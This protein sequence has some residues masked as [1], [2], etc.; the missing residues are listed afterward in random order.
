MGSPD[1]VVE[2]FSAGWRG[3]GRS[4]GRHRSCSRATLASRSAAES[5]TRWALPMRPLLM[6]TMRSARA[7]ASSTSWVT[8]SMEAWCFR[9]SSRTRSCIRTRVIASSDA[10]GSSSRI[11]SGSETSARA[12][13]T[14]W[15][16]PP[17]SCLGQA[18]SRPARFTSLSAL[19]ARLRRQGRAGRTS[20]CEERVA[21]EAIGRPETRSLVW[22]GTSMRPPSGLSN[23]ASRRSR[24][25]F[26]QPEG[27]S[28]TTSSSSPIVRSR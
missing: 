16:S 18:F 20:H 21:T 24:V 9:R 15:A 13:A 2:S 22:R 1:R 10:N 4:A 19:R 3:R 7:I 26:P 12:N 28:R 17:E 6:T 5:S 23:P 11:S 14:R 27:P 25:L 8:S